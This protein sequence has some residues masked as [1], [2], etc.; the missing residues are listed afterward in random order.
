MLT[1][2]GEAF[3]RASICRNELWPRRGPAASRAPC[4]L[5]LC[6]QVQKS[7]GSSGRSP[8]GFLHVHH[9]KHHYPQWASKARVLST[10]NKH[11]FS[12]LNRSASILVRED[13]MAEKKAIGWSELI[14]VGE[15]RVAEPELAWPHMQ[16]LPWPWELPLTRLS[17]PTSCSR[18][19]ISCK[20]F[21]TSLF[22]PCI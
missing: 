7:P 14:Y 20:T 8:S 22:S 18:E 12:V 10:S 9:D 6:V 21:T 15:L 3:H 4:H 17:L 16:Y 11:G 5:L 1:G 13:E 2:T 19:D